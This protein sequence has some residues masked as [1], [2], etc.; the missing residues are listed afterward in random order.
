MY[1]SIALHVCPDHAF[2]ICM[3]LCFIFWESQGDS[4]VHLQNKWIK[5]EDSFFHISE[6]V[7]LSFLTKRNQHKC[8]FAC[9]WMMKWE[10]KSCLPTSPLTSSER[11]FS[12]A[13][14]KAW[15]PQVSE[16]DLKSPPRPSCAAWD[17]SS[18]Y[19]LRFWS[20]FTLCLFFQL[21]IKCTW[22]STHITVN[23]IGL[24]S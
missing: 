4:M 21:K 14:Q 11:C 9:G 2:L 1:N 3:F 23:N 19:P 7:D 17:K 13:Y 15:E 22:I 12:F 24:E 8:H 18:P 5:I 16:T 10:Y 6:P 20:I